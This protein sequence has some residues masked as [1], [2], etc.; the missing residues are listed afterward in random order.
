MMK[1]VLEIAPKTKREGLGEFA[2]RGFLLIDATYTPVN[3]SHLSPRN[4][5]K[6]ILDDFPLLLEDLRKHSESDTGVILV[7]ANICDLLEPMLTRSGCTI[8]NRGKKVP[9][10]ST[11]NQS[12]FRTTVRPLLGM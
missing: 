6:M 8:L 11:G 7:K 4:R 2:A 3:H 9:F 10:P 12:K 5:D 1:D